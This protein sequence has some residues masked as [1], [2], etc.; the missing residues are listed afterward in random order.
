MIIAKFFDTVDH[1]KLMTIIMLNELDKELE[2]RGLDFVRYADD[3]IIMMGSRQA[4][5]RVRKSVTRFIEEK[6]GLEVNTEK[7]RGD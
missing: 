3:L 4:A 7:S 5:E 6:L 2:A 1:D